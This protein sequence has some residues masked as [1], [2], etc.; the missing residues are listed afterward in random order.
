MRANRRGSLSRCGWGPQL[1][2]YSRSDSTCFP[3]HSTSPRY[4]CPL[5][6]DLRL[7]LCKL[8]HVMC[9]GLSLGKNTYTLVL[10]VQDRSAALQACCPRHLQLQTSMSVTWHALC[11]KA[12][13]A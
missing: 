8:R 3:T 5:A 7:H 12:S 10:H 11:Q 2:Q 6:L 13:T 9:E 1:H 4:A